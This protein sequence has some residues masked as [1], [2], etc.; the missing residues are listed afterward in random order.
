M[1]YFV[2]TWNPKVWDGWSDEEWDSFATTRDPE[3]TDGRWSTG[4]RRYGI[5]PGDGLFFLRQGTSGRGILAFGSATSDIYSDV[6][7]LDPKK[8]APYIDYR[9]EVVVPLFGMLD[10]N[11]LLRVAPEFHWGD[12]YSSGNEIEESAALKVLSALS[13]SFQL[14]PSSETLPTEEDSHVYAEGNRVSVTT[15]R[16][17]RDPKARTACIKHYG[18]V[19]FVCGFDFE[20]VYGDRG[21]GFIEVHHLSPLSELGGSKISIDPIQD[22]RPLCSNCHSMIHRDGLVDPNA[23]RII[24]QDHA[25][26]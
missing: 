16:Y 12:V 19:C 24:L 26:G 18:H 5:S 9:W 3:L 15:N 11:E 20:K 1:K 8:M 25:K 7:Y 17:E 21:K 4:S 6:H 22:M 13:P 23:L 14:L 10:S 2:L